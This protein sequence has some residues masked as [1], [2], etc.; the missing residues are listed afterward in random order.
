MI[1]QPSPAFLLAILVLK[2][3][4]DVSLKPSAL[5]NSYEWGPTAEHNFAGAVTQVG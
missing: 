5:N 1:K 4:Y 3:H 2:G